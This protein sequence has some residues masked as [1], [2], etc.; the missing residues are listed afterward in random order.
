MN[1][2]IKQESNFVVQNDSRLFFDAQEALKGELTYSS[3]MNLAVS[4]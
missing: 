2:K 3:S 4:R 1:V